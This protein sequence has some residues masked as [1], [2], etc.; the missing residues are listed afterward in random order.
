VHRLTAFD[1]LRVPLL[2]EGAFPVRVHVQNRGNA[3]LEYVAPHALT[4]MVNGE[5]VSFPDF[6][7]L[8]G[9]DRE[10]VTMVSRGPVCLC[11]LRIG[12]LS[13][14]VLVLPYRLLGAFL[15]LAIGLLLVRRRFSFSFGVAKK[16]NGR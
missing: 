2:A 12:S 7:L 6:T 10:L 4:V 1:H 14:R 3:H 13:A 16:S 9:S 15:L 11:E 5:P 8:R